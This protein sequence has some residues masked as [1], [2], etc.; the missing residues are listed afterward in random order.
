MQRNH[1]KFTSPQSIEEDRRILLA[2]RKRFGSYANLG[3]HLGLKRH[4]ASAY[5][6]NWK[7]IGIPARL[8]VSRP[9][10]FMPYMIAASQDA[11]NSQKENP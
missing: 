8:K 10:L 1:R 11:Q 3:V 2:L 7:K 4:Q 5:I 9:D 6:C